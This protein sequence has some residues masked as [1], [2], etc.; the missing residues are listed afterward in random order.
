MPENWGR[1]CGYRCSLDG[2]MA[3]NGQTLGESWCRSGGVSADKRNIPCCHPVEGNGV[4]QRI[5][6]KCQKIG[7]VHADIDVLWMVVL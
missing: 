1:P 3:I 2:G 5:K 6:V 4:D 7:V